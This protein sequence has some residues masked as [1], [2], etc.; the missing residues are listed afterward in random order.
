METGGESSNICNWPPYYLSQKIII[1]HSS[2]LLIYSI[3]CSVAI[4]SN[5]NYLIYLTDDD[6][7]NRP[8]HVLQMDPFHISLTQNPK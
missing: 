7:M 4:Y 3:D 5:G 8:K 2:F 1:F 6:M